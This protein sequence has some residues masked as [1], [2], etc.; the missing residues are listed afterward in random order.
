MKD[1]TLQLEETCRIN[2]ERGTWTTA[3]IVV[4]GRPTSEAGGPAVCQS[5]FLWLGRVNILKHLQQLPE[6]LKRLFHVEK[7]SE[8]FHSQVFQKDN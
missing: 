3:S 4:L 1:T 2:Q 5:T 8:N 6:E 7:G